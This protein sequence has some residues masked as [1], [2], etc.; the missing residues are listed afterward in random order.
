MAALVHRPEVLFLD[1]PTLGLDVNA[2]AA[3]RNFL[4]DYNQKYG[5]TILL[6]SHYM[7]D[8]TALCK[9]VMVIHHGNLMY[10]GEL[11]GILERFAPYREV[12]VEL[13]QEVAKEKL[14]SYG[15]IDAVE[16]RSARVIVARE[17]LT[18]TVSRMLARNFAGAGPDGDGPTG[19]EDYWTIVLR[20]VLLVLRR[21]PS[22]DAAY[23]SAGNIFPR[24]TR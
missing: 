21:Q 8:I 9:R 10:D 2:Q 20:K 13:S 4:R 16:G 3:V 11:S 5:A 22:E 15:Q 19:G 23:G 1:E 18:G 24:T 14:E 6:T 12:V 17:G 7:A